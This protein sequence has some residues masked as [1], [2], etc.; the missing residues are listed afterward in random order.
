ME[1]HSIN[2]EENGCPGR[3]LVVK[4]MNCLAGESVLEVGVDAGLSLPCYPGRTSVVDNI[5]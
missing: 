2:I 5:I 3:R 1:K 4:K